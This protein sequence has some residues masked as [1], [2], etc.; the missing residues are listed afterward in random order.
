[1]DAPAAAPAVDTAAPSHTSSSS[2]TTTMTG[3]PLAAESVPLPSTGKASLPEP[4]KTSGGP[5]K[6]R[7]TL[8]DRAHHS[9]NKGSNKALAN[10]ASSSGD[11][12]DVG[13]GGGGAA[14]GGVF[15][16]SSKGRRSQQPVEGDNVLGTTIANGKANVN[17][18]TTDDKKKP[19]SRPPRRSRTNS[20]A[21]SNSSSVANG[22]GRTP[23][24]ASGNRMGSNGNSGNRQPRERRAS[25]APNGRD[26]GSKDAS[27]AQAPSI[28][29]E[30]VMM[31]LPTS[32]TQ[33]TVGATNASA[34]T[35]VNKQESSKKRGQNNNSKSA[36]KKSGDKSDKNEQQ[37]LQKQQKQPKQQQQQQNKNREDPSSSSSS[38]SSVSAPSPS[39]SSASKKTASSSAADSLSPRKKHGDHRGTSPKKTPT[40]VGRTK[41]Q[42]QHQ[43][44]ATLT[45]TGTTSSDKRG[46]SV[47][48]TPIDTTSASVT[49]SSLSS[50]CSFLTSSSSVSPDSPQSRRPFD[51]VKEEED[52]GENDDEEEKRDTISSLPRTT[53]LL[54]SSSSSS[55]SSSFSSSIHPT[56]HPV[57]LPP[58]PPFTSS[59]HSI[60]SLSGLPSPS[61]SSSSPSSSSSPAPHSPIVAPSSPSPSSPSPSARSS[62]HHKISP[63]MTSPSHIPHSSPSTPTSRRS[64]QLPLSDKFGRVGGLPTVDENEHLASRPTSFQ[65]GYQQQQQQQQ[66]MLPS[67]ASGPALASTASTAASQSMGAQRGHVRSKSM[68]EQLAMFDQGGSKDAPKTLQSLQD[69]ISS[70]KS[71]PPATSSAGTTAVSAGVS[72]SGVGGQFPQDTIAAP[73]LTTSATAAS[74][75]ASQPRHEKRLSM[76]SLPSRTSMTP[77]AREPPF[78]ST[79]TTLHISQPPRGTSIENALQSTVATLRRLSVSDSKRPVGLDQTKANNRRS[80]VL[81]QEVAAAAAAAT[82]AVGPLNTAEQEANKRNR[83]SVL[84]TP[85]ESHV[86]YQAQEAAPSAASAPSGYKPNR[87]SVIVKP[88]ELMAMQEGRLYIAPD[89]TSDEEPNAV[90]DALSALEGNSSKRSSLAS[91]SIHR[92]SISSTT[93]DQQSFA[94]FASRLPSHMQ[95]SSAAFQSFG[96]SLVNN[97]DA[98]SRR[99]YT[100]AFQSP[101]A[102]RTST[103]LAQS[104]AIASAANRR[105]SAMPASSAASS[106]D[107]RMST[108]APNGGSHRDSVSLKDNANGRR[109]LFMAHLTYSDFHSL[110]TK[111]KHKYVQGVLRIN[112]R[113]RSDAYVTVD[114]LPDGDVYICGSKDRNR[115]L[116]GDVV[117]IELIDFEDMPL[118]KLEG[119]KDKKKNKRNEDIDDAGMPD[120]EE[121]KPKY[122][123]R[124]VSIVERSAVQL[125][126]GTLALQRPSGST[127]K[128]ERRRQ[129]DDDSKGQPRIFWFK[130]TD[131]RVPLI[132]IPID[133]A[134]ADFIHNHAAY[135]HKLFVASI[136]R[137]PLSS[138]HPFGQ[139]ERELGDIGN[140][141]IETE[142]LLANN[143]VMTTAFGEKVEKCLPELPW[144]IT[145]KEESKREDLRNTCTFTI[146]PVTAKD[147]DDAVSCIKLDDGNYEVGVHIADVSHFIK[148]GSALDREAKSRATTVYLVQKAIPMLPNV[149]CED[150]CSLRANV[151]RLTFSVFWKMNDQ[152]E[153]L[154]TRFTKSIIRSCT[155][156]SYDDAQRVITSGN[157][158]PKVE[159]FGQPRDLV[160][161][162]IKIFFKLSQILR[163]R[164]FDNG[165]LSINSIRLAFETDDLQ[166]P[167]DVS[168][169]ELKESNRLIEEFML[170]ANMSVARQ[171]CQFFPEQALLRRHEQPLEKRMTEF[172]QNMRKVGIELDASSS[173]ALQA[174]LDAI[175]DP[176]IRKVIRLLVIKPMHR[177]KYICSGML[178]STKHHHYA[179][180]APVYTHFTSPIRR[181]ADIIVHRMLEASLTGE[182]KFYLN[183]ESCQ[184][185]ANHCNIKKDAAKV[186]QEQSSHL[187][188]SV[189]LKNLTAKHGS[190]VRDALVVRVL[191][192]AFDILVPEYGLE[193]R[194]YLEHLPLEKF[195]WLENKDQ[196]KLF[197]SRHAIKPVEDEQDA[198]QQQQE[199][200]GNNLQQIK[201]EDEPEFTPGAYAANDHP[202][203]A[204]NAYDDERGL[205][206][207]ESDYE[208]DSFGGSS[209][210]H[211]VGTTETTEGEDEDESEDA[212]QRVTR[213]KVFGK[214]QV[215][216]S[217]EMEMSP[218]VINITA[219]NPFAEPE[220]DEQQP[221]P[222]FA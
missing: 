172:I 138:L 17:S 92:R 183:K 98:L 86:N 144:L 32:H 162:N 207:D 209:V 100:T 29:S 78:P 157:L 106:K 132:A 104:T 13:D 154:D 45:T 126:S 158:D 44:Q 196:L 146:D 4:K 50:S 46:P 166:N 66:Q 131:K 210:G 178:D 41:Q 38:S 25:K 21:S 199:Q 182:S 75:A 188:L 192:A 120:V 179:L 65:Q 3:T 48:P 206:D 143:N 140:I 164:R 212:S 136:K 155:Q 33:A 18:G 201:E 160:E 11:G 190:V 103:N 167:L 24:G 123:G 221:V 186:A 101:T 60:H 198:Q 91:S 87:R 220:H 23:D 133:Q 216:L 110:L 64:S 42:Q 6:R 59:L 68:K 122:C 219:V 194:I 57:P 169:Y 70:L 93:A 141:E 54:S 117:G 58:P 128:N 15:A 82:A 148:V 153:I 189:L 94:E 88:E 102:N 177:A 10:G 80:V 125:F 9:N 107:W 191:D 124:V 16:N 7:S 47:L 97:D 31:P 218:P 134:P 193:K 222:H 36:G 114:S 213:V 22:G 163:Q 137:W 129:D 52:E 67:S 72:A 151:D 19:A 152:A 28:S 135:A 150:L 8:P 79:T 84:A 71:L 197:W 99:R 130:P 56:P 27:I 14:G 217:V 90:A 12:G 37:L 215:L 184:K 181:Y 109:P 39:P 111:Q 105:L 81:P 20:N 112:K 2:T 108:P 204:T 156:L 147:L 116:E 61:P 73:S 145:E 139:L 26:G 171:I 35:N 85:P 113:N 211:A 176:D 95:P 53:V 173:G 202:D 168:V 74:S 170:L 142:A 49:A 185:N 205:F 40:V 63:I 203:D 200:L 55:S 83:R 1:M 76:S 161:D 121:V 51:D 77:A 174:S 187:Y 195:T 180:N 214:L 115:A 69:I 5:N 127:K 208:D 62:L 165:A 119:G 175:Q 89:H 149:L 96:Q 159:V 118:S 30:T 43:Q 34:T